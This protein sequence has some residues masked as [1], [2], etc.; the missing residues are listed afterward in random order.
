VP[1][2]RARPRIN[3][4]R[5][6]GFPVSQLVRMPEPIVRVLEG[7]EA[8]RG[9]LLEAARAGPA[10]L[11][12][13]ARLRGAKKGRTVTFSKKAFLSL[14][15]LCRDTCSYCTY[16]SEPGQQKLSMMSRAQVDALMAEAARFGCV[17]ALVVAG[18]RP[19]QA[20]PEAR[21]WLADNGFS[22]TAEYAV[23]C[24]E[25]AE[26]AG[27]FPHTNI[28]NM[29][30]SEMS[31]LRKTNPSM[32]LM[33]E[34]SSLRLSGAGMPH[35]GAPSKDPRARIAA[36]ENAGALRIP[37]TTGVLVGI[38]E[39][40]PELV[41]SLLEIRRLHARWGHIQEVIVQNFV[42]KPDTAMAG[43]PPPAGYLESA[44]ALARLA[45]PGMNVQAPPN[46]SPGSCLALLDAGVNDLGGISPL[47]P[48]YV[49]PECPWPAIGSVERECAGAGFDLE[50][51]FPAYPEFWGMVE[52]RVRERMREMSDGRGL[53]AGGRWR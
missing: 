46:L 52:P 22:S 53:V 38:G 18:E 48:D 28:G 16:K 51:R 10:L 3:T 29:T 9:D 34:S 5:A 45:M 30:R 7:K 20:Y 26:A 13:A 37:M 32:G 36:L 35:Q 17:E 24:S 23:H 1:Q 14:V 27:L 2:L 44:I 49:N 25:R 15:S 41:D 21:A 4:G 11:Q 19:E 12:A 47:T 39:T 43:P 42:P 40:V 33:L 8:S 31:D 6:A 50:C